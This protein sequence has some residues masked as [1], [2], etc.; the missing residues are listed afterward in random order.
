[1][2]TYIG[3]CD[4]ACTHD[5]KSLKRVLWKHVLWIWVLWIFFDPNRLI[6][7]PHSGCAFLILVLI[8]ILWEILFLSNNISLHVHTRAATCTH[9]HTPVWHDG[10]PWTRIHTHKIRNRNSQRIAIKTKITKP[11][12]ERSWNVRRFESKKI[13]ETQIH[14]TSFHKPCLMNLLSW[15]QAPSSY[16]SYLSYLCMYISYLCTHNRSSHTTLS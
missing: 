15:V 3:F 8:A 9:T 7:E 13:H 14:K 6:L 1:M 5:N 12:L 10:N 4:G 2:H 16:L 11:Q